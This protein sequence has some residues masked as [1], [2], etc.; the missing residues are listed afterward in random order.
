MKQPFYRSA[1]L[2]LVL[3]LGAFRAQ[4]Q[5]RNNSLP[6]IISYKPG[7]Y[8]LADGSWRTGQLYREP[9]ANLRVRNP[10]DKKITT[11]QPA[12]VRAFVIDSDTFRV[13]HEVDISAR[14]RLSSAF[15]CQL[16]RHGQYTAFSMEHA[17]TGAAAYLGTGLETQPSLVV[18]K[19][20][21]PGVVVPATRGA[22]EKAMLPLFG[23]CPE[24]AAKI[25]AGTVGRQ[26]TRA[27]LQTYTQWQQA[28]SP[29][30]PTSAN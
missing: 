9:G 22:F 4:A 30:Q 24:L 18:Q 21:G 19:E 15:A 7:Q 29:Q 3:S 28:G 1:L 6:R 26:H 10:E 16:Y 20:N 13:V 25:K 27:I 11:Y 17:L 5:Y 12:E 23:D 8:Q 14:R 2:V